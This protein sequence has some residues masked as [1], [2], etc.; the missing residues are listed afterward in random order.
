MNPMMWRA[1]ARGVNPATGDMGGDAFGLPLRVVGRAR[2]GAGCK[3]R[4]R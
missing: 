2:D 1:V 3:G 4:S